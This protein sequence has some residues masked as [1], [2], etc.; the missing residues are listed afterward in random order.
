VDS[1][2]GT[3]MERPLQVHLTHHESRHEVLAQG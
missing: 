2:S 1:G 3:G